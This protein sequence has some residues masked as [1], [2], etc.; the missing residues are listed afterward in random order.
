MIL[1]VDGLRVSDSDRNAMTGRLSEALRIRTISFEDPSQVDDEEFLKFH[2]FLERSFP[3]VHSELTREVVSGRSLLFT[4]QGETSEPAVLLLAHLDVV[5]IEPGTETRWTHPPF[6]GVVAGGSIWGRGAMDDK[7]SLIAILEAAERLSKTGFKPRRTICFA[8]GHDEE[9]GGSSGATAIAA[10]LESRGF[11]ASF[12]LDEGGGIARVPGLTPPA[13]LVGIAEKGTVSLELSV[14]TDGGHS[15]AP[16]SQT[17]VGILSRAMA[18]LQDRPLPAALS[19]PMRELFESIG[20]E[21][22]FPL[23]AVVANLWLFEPLLLRQLAAEPATNAMIRTTTAPTMIDG[24]VKQ[25]VIPARA[26]GVV[27]FRILPGDTTA[28]VV[29][30]VRRV[31]DDPRVRIEIVRPGS[32]VE[33][34]PVSNTDDPAFATLQRAIRG[35]FPDAIVAPYL[36]IGATDAR[37]YTGISRNIYRFVPL[38]LG[39]D[40][41]RLMHGTN[42]RV[43]VDEYI[44]M[45]GFYMHLMKQAA[46]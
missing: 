43:P 4:W 6:D 2:R 3:E 46:S 5:P 1:P 39:N 36:T 41:M 23:R 18:R 37:A 24:G 25:N 34:S 15:S 42:E 10:L 44:K 30:H 29:E 13:A 27:N 17:T 12:V 26:R 22:T 40:A 21:S 32:V 45:V 33:P 35:D 19:G 11:R 28:S 38:R 7:S 31:V 8:F 9:L 20:A 16:P 14:E